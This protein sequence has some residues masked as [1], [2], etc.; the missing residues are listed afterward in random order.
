MFSDHLLAR[1][2]ARPRFGVN[3][4]SHIFTPLALYTVLHISGHFQGGEGVPYFRVT[5]TRYS[6]F[7]DHLLAPLLARPLARPQV[8]VNWG[9]P[10]FT[11]LALYTP[12]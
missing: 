11:R 2:F 3:W 1:L 12:Y 5:R 6:M 8:G 10:I 7:S 4:G 9:S